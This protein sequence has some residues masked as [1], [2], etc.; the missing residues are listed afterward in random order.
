MAV[1]Y[2]YDSS[3]PVPFNYLT[4][5]RMAGELPPPYE[6]TMSPNLY[7]EFA[8]ADFAE[9]SQRGFVNA[10]GNVKRALHFTVDVLLNQYGLFT[11]FSKSNFPAKLQLLDDIGILPITIVRNLNVE[12]NLVEHEYDGPPPNRVAEAIDVVKLLLLATEK[13]LESTPHEVI[14]GWNSPKRHVLLQVEPVIGELRLYIVHAKGQ[15]KKING[16]SCLS[17]IRDFGGK[18]NPRIKIPKTPWKVIALNKT[19]SNEWK[20]I[21]REL[22]NI[23]RKNSVRK[24]VMDGA[25]AEVI[26]PITVPLPSLKTESWVKIID[27]ALGKT[28]EEEE[29]VPSKSKAKQTPNSDR[30]H[31]VE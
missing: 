15:Y 3:E 14:I 22:V 8:I 4:P 10:F 31:A 23:Q 29:T 6:T 26:I 18:L 30:L 17:R 21:I 25:K 9:G 28:F 16:I 19:H 12:R 20:P 7:L 24:S 1:Y 27:E 11:H 13:L 5:S 2:F